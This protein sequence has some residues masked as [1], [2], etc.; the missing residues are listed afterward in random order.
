MIDEDFELGLAAHRVGKLDDAATTYERI[1]AERPD[2]FGALQ[3][4]GVI[5][6]QQG[7][8][9]RA[10]ELIQ[11]SLAL[12]ATQTIAYVNLGNALMGLGRTSEAETAYRRASV[13]AP[14][15]PEAMFGL[16]NALRDGR[17]D[18]ALAAYRRAIDLRPDFVEAIANLAGTYLAQGKPDQALRHWILAARLRPTAVNL[19]LG[20]ARSLV[21][22]DRID[23]ASTILRG[24]GDL[25]SVTPD[26]LF[27]AGNLLAQMR[28]FDD[29]ADLYRKILSAEPGLIP[30]V[31]NLGNMLRELG[32]LDEAEAAYRDALTLQPDNSAII[33][34]RALILK[35]LGGIA[36]AEAECRR[37]LAI[38]PTAIAHNNLGLILYFCGR[39][40]EALAQFRAAG[41]LA[42]GLADVV[43]HE[44]VV[45]LHLGRLAE[46]WPKYEARWGR[47]RAW[48]RRRE[49]PRPL[50]RG[51]P[52]NGR[53]ILVH[54]EQGFGDTLQFVRYAPLLAAHGAK[55]VLECQPALVRLM[56]G[57][58]GVS[59]V[60]PR[61]APL[62]AFD[63]H[64]PIMS[65]PLAFG[66]TL[67]TIPADIPYVVAP[68]DAIEPRPARLAATSGL[69][70]G[71]VWTGDARH[72]DIECS[73]TDRRRS[74]P[75]AAFASFFDTAG[76]SFFSLQVGPAASQARDFP[77]LIDLTAT[78]RDFA[79]TAGL[80]SHLDLV[81]SVD[82][83]V[84]HL[85]ASMGKPVWLLSRFDG[86]W[87]WM[88]ERDDSPWYPTVRLFRQSAP[89]DWAPVL[90]RIRVELERWAVAHGD[91][92]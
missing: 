48:E 34:N 40:T 25:L 29:A 35:D 39:M 3:L 50:W 65:L 85:A 76:V 87:R 64:C 49:F 56:A 15:L 77:G 61:G 84:A 8:F 52:L 42:P 12:D 13:L 81:I 66:T 58:A 83:A 22:L 23:E 36:E 67:E 59:Q 69:R 60:V 11:S 80:I 72:Y 10:V 20:A 37:S 21:A 30:A 86:C 33:C 71:I 18:E 63:L 24:I 16:G 26:E 73:M 31:N 53:T 92:R 70:V 75:L 38:E 47:Q 90:E 6:S 5:A 32:R 82:T 4:L 43:F 89:G 78:I 68:S 17:P 14:D 55:V 44:G 28:R 91:I 74:L 57:V 62:P 1:I 7:H 51:E 45:L 19:H 9:E 79:D 27:E 46:G 2:H 88:L 54:A 41:A